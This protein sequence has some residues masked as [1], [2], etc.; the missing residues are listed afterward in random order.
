MLIQGARLPA[1]TGQPA[2][3]RQQGR[4]PEPAADGGAP[5]VR[6]HIGRVQVSPAPPARQAP[7]PAAAVTKLPALSLADYLKQSAQPG[8]KA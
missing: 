1:L 8:G 3:S 6:V 7:R 2:L 5:V 4:P